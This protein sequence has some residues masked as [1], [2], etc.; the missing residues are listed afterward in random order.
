MKQ[1]DKTGFT[2]VELMVVLA[3]LGVVMVG[4]M[5]VITHQNKAYH[6][7]ESIIDLQM[8][9]RIALNQISRYVR[10]AGFGCCGNIDSSHQVNS[11]SSVLNATDNG[12]GTPDT[13]TIVTA[14]R[15]VGIVDDG[16]DPDHSEEFQSIS[17]IPVVKHDSKDKIEELFNNSA[18]K[19]IYIAPCEN[20]DFLTISGAVAAA[21]TT[22][23]LN[24]S[25]RVKEGTEIFTVKAYSISIKQPNEYSAP[26]PA[27]PN[28]VINENT[29][30]NRQEFA[31]N[32]ENLQFQYG[33]DLNGDGV[34]NP[35]DSNDWTDDPSGNEADIKAVR[36][37]VLAR[38]AY[39]DREY[40]VNKKEYKY[41]INDATTSSTAVT[42]T[43]DDQYHRF[44]L[45]TTVM[46]RNLNIKK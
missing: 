6:S 28:L 13:L 1:K 7:E 35:T 43:F 45:K 30:G 41:I 37:Y 11:F 16:D 31:E 39:P 18:K 29:G 2:L 9:A 34:F 10:M 36:I 24:S 46:V 14:G 22:I 17:A 19:Y 4:V 33:W 25:I 15:A 26:K 3:I 21:A 5:G 12:S 38:S 27:G 8:N 40:N 23:T 32:I 44:L 20:S 42:A